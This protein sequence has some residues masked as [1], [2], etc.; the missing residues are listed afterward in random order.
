MGY[1]KTSEERKHAADVIW[2][3]KKSQHVAYEHLAEVVG[4]N[5]VWVAAIQGQAAMSKEEAVSLVHC[6]HI[7]ND[8]VFSFLTEIPTKGSLGGQC[9]L[10]HLYIGFMK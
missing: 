2:E 1:S 7:D 5:K 6:L 8:D 3:A 9:P 4:R 10:I